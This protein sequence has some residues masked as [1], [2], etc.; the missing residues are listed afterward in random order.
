MQVEALD[1]DSVLI[2]VGP[3]LFSIERGLQQPVW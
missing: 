2:L 3:L 1:T